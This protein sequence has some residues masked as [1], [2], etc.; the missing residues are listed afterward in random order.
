VFGNLSH[1]PLLTCPAQALDAVRKSL[2]TRTPP[3]KIWNV[4]TTTRTH[5]RSGDRVSAPPLKFE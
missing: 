2:L 1:I 5:E 3:T 4:M